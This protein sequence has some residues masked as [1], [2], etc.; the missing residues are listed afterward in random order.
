MGQNDVDSA[1]TGLNR[2]RDLAIAGLLDGERES[3]GEE[4]VR[5]ADVEGAMGVRRVGADAGHV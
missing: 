2:S 4:A 3:A 1:D 5:E